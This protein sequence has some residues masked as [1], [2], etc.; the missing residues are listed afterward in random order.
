MGRVCCGRFGKWAIAREKELLDI[1]EL[2]IE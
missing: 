1:E 2:H